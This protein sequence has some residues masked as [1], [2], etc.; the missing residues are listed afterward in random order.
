MPEK[1]K[2]VHSLNVIP[3]LKKALN[4]AIKNSP[5]SRVHIAEKMNELLE[6][7]GSDFR[8]SADM[9][10]SWTKDD[11][12]RIIPL[13][14]LP[15]FCKVTDSILPIAAL[16][17]PLEAKVIRGPEIDVLNLGFAELERL[18][19]KQRKSSAMGKLGLIEE[20][21]GEED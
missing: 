8:V 17:R 1:D 4:V 18:R 16:I 21:P 20:R 10:N 19:V 12:S 9:I 3:D 13:K 6:E 15:H 2:K 7:E 11:P 5:L 14:I